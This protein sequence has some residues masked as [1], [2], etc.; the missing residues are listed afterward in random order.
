[1]AKNGDSFHQQVI[2]YLVHSIVGAYEN[3][4]NRQF[5]FDGFYPDI[6]VL[7]DGRPSEIHEVMTVDI[8]ELSNEAKRVLWIVLQSAWEEIHVIKT[9]LFQEDNIMSLIDLEIKLKMSIIDLKTREG[10]VK[11]KVEELRREFGVLT[12]KRRTLSKK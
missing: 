2:E 5:D 1:M 12:E 8:R 3:H 11:K 7:K 4:L 9:P 10:I 6:V